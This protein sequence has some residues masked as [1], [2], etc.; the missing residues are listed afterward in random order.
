MVAM[1]VGKD[2]ARSIAMKGVVDKHKDKR[3]LYLVRVPQTR[4]ANFRAC[5]CRQVPAPYHLCLGLIPQAVI[6]IIPFGDLVCN[7][8]IRRGL[9]GLKFIQE[10]CFLRLV[11]HCWFASQ[12]QR[13][14]NE[15][16]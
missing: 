8:N 1:A 16:L 12:L 13:H 5:P 14:L 11:S 6:D 10:L 9:Y 3:N 2:D 15:I 4:D 7:S